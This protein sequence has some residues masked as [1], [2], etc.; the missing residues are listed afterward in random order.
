[1][2]LLF[3]KTNCSLLANERT[4]STMYVEATNQ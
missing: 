4:A 1:M 2:V 3:Y